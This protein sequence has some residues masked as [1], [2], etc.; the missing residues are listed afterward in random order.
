MTIKEESMKLGISIDALKRRKK[1]AVKSRQNE[2]LRCG[3]ILNKKGQLESPEIVVCMLSSGIL[4]K[5]SS[6]RIKIYRPSAKLQKYY[7]CIMKNR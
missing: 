3:Y 6:V 4:P 2:L 5:P 1:E 7:F